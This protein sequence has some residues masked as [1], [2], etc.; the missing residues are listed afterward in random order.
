M[1]GAVIKEIEKILE[2]KDV[3]CDQDHPMMLLIAMYT[4]ETWTVGEP[5]L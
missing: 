4:R 1:E 3:T 2:C 5:T